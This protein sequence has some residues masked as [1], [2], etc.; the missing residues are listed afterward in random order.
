MVLNEIVRG[1]V[2]MGMATESQGLEGEGHGRCATVDDLKSAVV[3]VLEEYTSLSNW[4][5][6]TV[7]EETDRDRQDQRVRICEPC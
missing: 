6:L 2:G 3:S 7:S 1:A 4:H 5:L